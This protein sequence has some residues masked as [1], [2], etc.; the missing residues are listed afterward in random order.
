[1]EEVVVVEQQDDLERMLAHMRAEALRRGKDW[2]CAKMEER[3]DEGQLT[4][5]T[6]QDGLHTT[7]DA[8]DAGP[9]LA[10]IPKTSKRQRTAGKPPKKVTKKLRG[11]CLATM[12]SA[13]QGEP[14]PSCLVKPTEGEH[15]SEIIKECFKF[16]A[17]LLLSGSSAGLR[18]EGA[19]TGGVMRAQIKRRGKAHTQLEISGQQQGTPRRLGV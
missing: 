16:F 13:A 8:G 17:P 19:A 2:F 10:P 7:V 18:L 6:E 3:S 5:M 11:T 15:I 14:V 12:A 4:N 1:M 9:I